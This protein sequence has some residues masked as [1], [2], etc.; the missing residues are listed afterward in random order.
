M[1]IV[2]LELREVHAG[3]DHAL[4][5]QGETRLAQGDDPRPVFGVFED[6]HF[7]EGVFDSDQLGQGLDLL[8]NGVGGENPQRT[9]A[10]QRRHLE[11]RQEQP[12]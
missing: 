4:G 7:L 6:D 3:F 5:Q 12:H 8:E 10:V 1:D 11:Q 9:R 2:P